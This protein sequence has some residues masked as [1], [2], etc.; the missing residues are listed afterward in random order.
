MS[1]Q[2]DTEV[3]KSMLR[4]FCREIQVHRN[5]RQKGRSQ[6]QSARNNKEDDSKSKRRH[7]FDTEKA[8]RRQS[9]RRRRLR[10]RR[11]QCEW[12]PMTYPIIGKCSC[13]C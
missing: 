8:K 11:L 13:K 10:R 5:R 9:E 2:P 4:W 3:Q 7:D 1:C 12:V 6:H